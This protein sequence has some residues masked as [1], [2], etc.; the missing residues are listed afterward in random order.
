MTGL[1][2]TCLLTLDSCTERAHDDEVV[3]SLGL[4]PFVC[5]LTLYMELVFSA[6]LVHGLDSMGILSD[7][8][9]LPKSIIVLSQIELGAEPIIL[10]RSSC[11]SLLSSR[12]AYSSTSRISWSL[13]IP[14]NG[15]S[16]IAFKRSRGTASAFANLGS[17]FSA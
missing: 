6:E 16:N 10:K 15:F 7:Q 2:P 4:T 8:G 3:Q 1:W 5:G 12:A 9:A 14:S 13:G 17:L 11:D